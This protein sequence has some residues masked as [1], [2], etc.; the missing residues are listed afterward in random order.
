MDGALARWFWRVPTSRLGRP[1]KGASR[2]PALL[3]PTITAAW[4]ISSEK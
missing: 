3:L 4:R 1:R 2:T